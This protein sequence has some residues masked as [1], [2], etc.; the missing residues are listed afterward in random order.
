MFGTVGHD[1]AEV[2][3]RPSEAGCGVA[4]RCEE[5]KFFPLGRNRGGGEFD[6]VRFGIHIEVGDLNGGGLGFAG[7][8]LADEVTGQGKI[9]RDGE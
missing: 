2:V 3:N 1:D 8:V 5:L 9:S 6:G 4:V 7:V